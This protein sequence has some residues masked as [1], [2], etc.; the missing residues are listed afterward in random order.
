M[1]GLHKQTNEE[2]RKLGRIIRE[3]WLKRILKKRNK[4]I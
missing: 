4:R 1:P 3:I 2:F